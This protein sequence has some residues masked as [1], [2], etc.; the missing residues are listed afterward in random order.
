MEEEN[1]TT[2]VENKSKLHI[3]TPL[4]KYLVMTLFIAMPFIGGYIGYTF[5]PE[6]VIEKVVTKEVSAPERI[7]VSRTELI[8]R[9][10]ELMEQ[11]GIEID[12]VSG[13]APLYF[14]ENKNI[15]D[16]FVSFKD[17]GLSMLLPYNDGWGA[18][19]YRFTPYDLNGDMLLYGFIHPCAYG[20]SGSGGLATGRIKF[21]APDAS[22]EDISKNEDIFFEPPECLDVEVNDYVDGTYC[23]PAGLG[24]AILIIKG[25]QHTY[26]LGRWGCGQYLL[27]DDSLETESCKFIHQSIRV[28]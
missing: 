21:H 3:V 2:Q 11:F 18:P 22:V 26:E 16:S 8:Q 15:Q 24:M 1:Q 17:K 27:E 7:T 12:E 13:T 14:L 6:K 19:F 28:D 10:V 9:E 25:S 20:C 4:S 5:A 23:E